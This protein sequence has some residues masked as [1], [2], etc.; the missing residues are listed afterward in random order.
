MAQLGSW[1]GVVLGLGST[2]ETFCRE[3][4]DPVLL[5]NIVLMQH[6]CLPFRLVNPFRDNWKASAEAALQ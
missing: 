4:D 6:L 1:S 3:Q 2:W 5:W